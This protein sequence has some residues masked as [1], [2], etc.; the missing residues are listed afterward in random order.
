[1]NTGKEPGKPLPARTVK[2]PHG[3]RPHPGPGAVSAKRESKT[4]TVGRDMTLSGEIR[5]CER[6]VV[7]GE[8][9]STLE[10]CQILEIARG[11]SFRGKA[12]VETAKV[13]GHFEG[14]MDVEGCLILRATGRIVGTIRYRDIEIERGGKIAG[15]LEIVGEAGTKDRGETLP[16]AKTPHVVA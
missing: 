12:T 4:L 5:S 7:E 14:E 16:A 9:R 10:D 11:G 3:P 15:T 2:M 8:V 13:A 6:L 1:M